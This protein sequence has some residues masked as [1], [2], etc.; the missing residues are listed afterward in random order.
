MNPWESLL[1]NEGRDIM[2]IRKW[3]ALGLVAMLV[4]LTGCQSIGGLDVAK[5][6]KQQLDVKSAESKS[7]V[8]LKLDL[9]DNAKLSDEDKRIIQWLN[10]AQITIDAK[11]QDIT[12]V[13]ME[14]KLKLAGQEVPFKLGKQDTAMALWVEGAK[15]P[16]I[17]SDS[18]LVAGIGMLPTDEV[19]KQA[20]S[21]MKS[22]VD[23]LVKHAPNPK[24]TDVSSVNEQVAGE[25]LSLK[26]LHMEFTGEELIPW[27]KETLQSLLKDEAGLKAWFQEMGKLYAP[28]ITAGM[29]MS[30]GDE[31]GQ[32]DFLKDGEVLGLTAY[33]WVIENAPKWVEE[34]DAAY[35]KLVKETPELATVLGP[36][37]KLTLDYYVD[38]QSNVRKSSIQLN[39]A[40][41]AGQEIPLKGITYSITSELSN[42]NGNVK[43]DVIDTANA[44]KMD[45]PNMTPGKWLNHF[46]SKSVVYSW[47]KG[48]GITSKIAMLP[49]K[50]SEYDDWFSDDPLPYNKNGSM[51][52]PLSE[53]AQQFDADLKYDSSTKQIAIIDDITGNRI[54]MKL[55]SK[56]ATAGGQA[57][58]LPVAPELK[59]GMIFAPLR[60]LGD[61]LNFTI[62]FEETEYAS[63]I[64]LERK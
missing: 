60:S 3:L 62:K 24:Q 17:I 37:T 58:T 47:L 54:E 13:S 42:I 11:T 40:L 22:T 5:V 12:H 59:D 51:M 46:D 33:K 25:S 48:M 29:G 56:E 49:M 21:F 28:I 43:A 45:D 23:L 61:M 14:G 18:G 41:P 6:L 53:V 8:S 16:L 26:K 38:G 50:S 30:L 44:V 15:S 32:L 34:L 36:N 64:M 27:V 57:M 9:A 19:T 31:S 63:W 20:Q 4:V 7:T 39:V 2:R 1:T 10:D 35:A 52:A 55:G